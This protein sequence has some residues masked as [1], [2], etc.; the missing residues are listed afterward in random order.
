LVKPGR[1]LHGWIMSIEPGL[2]KSDYRLIIWCKYKNLLLDRTDEER[3]PNTV[4]NEL[5]SVFGPIIFG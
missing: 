5:Y 3:T 1:N 4:E 2:L